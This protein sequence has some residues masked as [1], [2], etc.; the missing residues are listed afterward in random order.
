MKTAGKAENRAATRSGVSHI[1]LGQKIDWLHSRYRFRAIQP[2]RKEALL[3]DLCAVMGILIISIPTPV[4]LIISTLDDSGAAPAEGTTTTSHKRPD[5]RVKGTRK[6]R[7]SCGWIGTLYP[8][9]VVST[10]GREIGKTLEASTGGRAGHETPSPTASGSV[11]KLAN[12]RS[13]NKG[14][15][16]ISG[17]RFKSCRSQWMTPV[18]LSVPYIRGCRVAG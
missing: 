14:Y 9:R 7:G 18:G 2:G 6:R 5:A 8:S 17:C 11:A 15:A 4:G 10:I 16:R 12:C 1:L 13:S 3:N